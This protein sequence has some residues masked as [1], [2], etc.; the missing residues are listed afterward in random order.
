LTK[1]TPA[2]RLELVQSIEVLDAQPNI[3]DLESKLREELH[4]RTFREYLDAMLHSVEGW[5][6]HKVVRHLAGEA[7]NETIRAIDLEDQIQSIR[8]NHK[9][10]DLPLNWCYKEVLEKIDPQ[11]DDRV[12]VRQLRVIN[13]GTSTLSTAICDHYKASR[14]RSQWIRE[15]L[16]Y[17]DEWDR[18]D[19]LLID[20]WRRRFDYMIEDVQDN[21][22]ETDLG[23][24]GQD[25]YRTTQDSQIHLRHDCTHPVIMRGAY[26]RLAD[27]LDLGWHPQWQK[28]FL[29]EIADDS[30][31]MSDQ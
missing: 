24:K 7:H 3:I 11:G 28:L 9:Q 1:P 19:H 16:L 29:R 13:C 14:E 17:L 12:F 6:F 18:Y 22:T 5:W 4:G 27:Q 30:G 8:E 25:L 21:A 31:E 23:R 2:K 20:E 10:N 26:H 15:R